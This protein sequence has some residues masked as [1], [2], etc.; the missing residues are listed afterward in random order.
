MNSLLYIMSKPPP[1]TWDGVNAEM[2]QA[3]LRKRVGWLD[4]DEVAGFAYINNVVRVQYAYA[5]VVVWSS[6]CKEVKKIVENSC[7]RVNKLDPIKINGDALH[8]VVN[9]MKRDQV[10]SKAKKG[11][12]LID[13]ILART[14]WHREKDM[15]IYSIP[16]LLLLPF[17]F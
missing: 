9:V 12:D 8:S 5:P 10:H 13:L 6:S 1:V 4:T 7:I 17:G 3:H 11:D 16:P 15:V 2:Y 14:Q